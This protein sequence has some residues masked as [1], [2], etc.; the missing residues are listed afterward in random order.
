MPHR[1]TL[2]QL[3]Y[4]VLTIE[5][6]S[7]AK[8]ASVLNVAQP[9]VSLAIGKL[10]DQFGTQLLLRHHAQGVSATASAER[11]L[12]MKSRVKVRL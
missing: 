6:G 1:F 11:I 4:L 9:T 10:E 5:L 2:R 3:E 7:I 12:A 8:A